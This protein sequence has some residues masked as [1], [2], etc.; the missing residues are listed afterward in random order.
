M[1]AVL[2]YLALSQQPPPAGALCLAGS[3][4]H[5]YTVRDAHFCRR[6]VIKATRAAVFARYRIPPGF[7]HLYELDHV[8]P[9][10]LGGS[11]DPANLWPEVWAHAHRKDVLENR[12]C[13]ALRAGRV[14]QA[15]AVAELR[16]SLSP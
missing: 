5:A 10:C 2:L 7:W 16:A 1:T 11:N 15:D 14:T 8:I 3:P 9:L 13:A 6:H 4:D 12:L